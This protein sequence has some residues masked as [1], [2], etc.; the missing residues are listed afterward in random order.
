[1]KNEARNITAADRNAWARDDRDEEQRAMNALPTPTK[2]ATYTI[3]RTGAGRWTVR[4]AYAN[5]GRIAPG[6]GTRWTASMVS[7][8][9]GLG[10]FATRDGAADAIIKAFE[11]GKKIEEKG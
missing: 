11:A 3:H 10:D 8:Y 5:I 1:M 6:R 2:D 7:G 9:A 4:E